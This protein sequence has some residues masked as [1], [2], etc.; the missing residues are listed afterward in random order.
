MERTISLLTL[1]LLTL[2]SVHAQSLYPFCFDNQSL[3]EMGPVYDVVQDE[4]GLHWLATSKGLCTFDGYRFTPL[5]GYASS[6]LFYTLSFNPGSHEVL[7]GGKNG[8]FYYDRKTR[9]THQ[10]NGSKATDIRTIAYAP[11]MNGMPKIFVGGHEGLYLYHQGKL[12]LLSSL[13]KDIFCLFNAGKGL[14]I[15]TLRGLYYY[16]RGVCTKLE[17]P[18]IDKES[19]AEAISSID[20]DEETGHFWLGTF[21]GLFVYDP[22]RHHVTPTKLNNIVIKHLEKY[23]EGLLISSDD[24]LYTYNKNSIGHY[25]HDSRIASSIGNDIVWSSFVDKDHNIILA[26]DLGLSIVH[27]HGVC[28]FTSLFDLTHL[29]WGNNI[30][31]LFRDSRHALWIGGS[32]GVIRLS[33]PGHPM[34][35]VGGSIWFRQNDSNHPLPHNHVRCITEDSNHRVWVS[36]DIGIGLYDQAHGKI[37]PKMIVDPE[38]GLNVPWIYDIIE[39]SK[40]QLWMTGIGNALYAVDAKGLEKAPYHYRAL[41]KIHF[42][43]DIHTAWQIIA[44]HDQ[45]WARTDQGLVSVYLKKGS[46]KVMMRGQVEY[47]ALDSQH[48][49]WAASQKGLSEYDEKG[50]VIRK[51]TFNNSIQQARIVGLVA[52]KDEIWILTPSICSIYSKGQW[53]GALRIPGMKANCI[54]DDKQNDLV[55]IGGNNGMMTLSRK[56]GERAYKSSPHLILSQLFVNERPFNAK[57]GSVM[58][59]KEIHLKHNDNNLRMMLSDFPLNEAATGIYA[60]QLKGFDN[61]WHD[62]PDLSDAIVYNGLPHGNYTLQINRLH[63]FGDTG[64]EVYKLDIT[65]EAPWYLSWWAKICY[66]AILVSILV[67]IVNLHLARRRVK[68]EREAR[69]HAMEESQKQMSFYNSLSARLYKGLE[70]VMSGLARLME[71]GNQKELEAIGWQTTLL[72]ANVRQALDMGK[73]HDYIEKGDLVVINIANYSKNVLMSM[74]D[75]ASS[76]KINLN[77]GEWDNS[78]FY[79]V[80]IIEW[81]ATI[82]IFIRSVILYSEEGAM[83]TFSICQDQGSKCILLS[84]TSNKFRVADDALPHFFQRYSKLGDEQEYLPQDM[85]RVKEYADRNKAHTAIFK[86]GEDITLQLSL[87]ITDAM[88][89]EGNDSQRHS[90]L[91]EI[92]PA[93]EKLMQEITKAIEDHIS[94]SE[95]NVTKLQETIGIGSKLLYRKTKQNTGMSP[96]EFIR[97]VRMKQAA[98]LLSQ[99]KFSVSSVMYMVGFSN[100]GYFSK[101]FQKEF[102][103]TPTQY[104]R[105]S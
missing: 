65:I 83:V 8:L 45:L 19:G 36:T 95:F 53:K 60:Y 59:L 30:Q 9:K 7:M 58:N 73:M 34:K 54:Y 14:Y 62:L 63:G 15:G 26:T 87:P 103:V 4:N 66:L 38:T 48:H 93:D 88:K 22:Y 71:K 70:H 1:A 75:E 40:G 31:C 25:V 28:S 94:D 16:S 46:I 35:E 2:L 23:K 96:V 81:D 85:Y 51:V 50:R 21:H 43:H 72:N 91:I 49:L 39:N 80:N 24:G 20:W 79:P 29:S 76:R 12:K 68:Q 18:G 42:G 82:F 92:D 5:T 11:T 102:G 104:K 99:G 56:W 84:L 13:P 17:L 101:C 32:G 57:E 33:F 27:N 98:L 77:M 105:N 10:I 74:K 67:V 37:I 78:I 69:H 86:N 3:N 100:S 97:Y 44:N 61:Q 52:I 64:N 55:Y 89:E 47:M 41:K 90:Q 6:Q